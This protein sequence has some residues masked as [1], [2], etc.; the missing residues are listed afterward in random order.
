MAG[1]TEAFVRALDGFEGVVL[2]F[3][4]ERWSVVTTCDPWTALDLAGHV[5]GAVRWASALIVGSGA[6]HTLRRDGFS[7]P[8]DL[9]VPDPLS[10][11]Y[12]AR[13]EVSEVVD[14]VDP[15]K[16][17]SW[18]FGEQTVDTGLQWF[19]LE[20]LIHTWD[21]AGATGN[22]VR[23]DPQLV[24]AHLLRLKPLSRFLRG[25]GGYG[26]ELEAPIGSNEQDQLLAFL[27][28]RL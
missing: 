21:L 11:W 20:V 10:A 19:S 6:D 13:S 16:L 5:I 7:S 2:Q 27:G 3:P 8:A 12:S 17:V 25:P 4:D 15:E 1:G 14:T 28:R 22:G 24:H 18:P 9:A 26:P 23:L